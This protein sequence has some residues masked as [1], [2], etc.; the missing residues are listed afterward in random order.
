MRSAPHLHMTEGHRPISLKC[1]LP[2]AA[3]TLSQ[4]TGPETSGRPSPRYEGQCD[5]STLQLRCPCNVR[6]AGSDPSSRVTFQRDATQP[7]PLQTDLIEGGGRLALWRLPSLIWG[8]MAYKAILYRNRAP[9]LLRGPQG[10]LSM[11][12]CWVFLSHTSPWG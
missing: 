5:S 11:D 8:Q 3:L 4:D 9:P 6:M 1:V 12:L 2:I 7:G 10:P